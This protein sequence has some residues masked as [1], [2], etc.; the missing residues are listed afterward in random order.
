VVGGA[1]DAAVLDQIS[2]GV[3]L[4][5]LV[6]RRPVLFYCHFPDK[7]LSLGRQSPSSALYRAPIDWLEER[8]TAAADVIFANSEFTR[9]TTAAEFRFHRSRVASS[10]RASISTR[11]DVP[12]N[13]A[14]VRLAVRRAVDDA[15]RRAAPLL[16][17]INRFERKKRSTSRSPPLAT[18]ARGG[19]RAAA[20]GPRRTCCCAA[21]TTTP[22]PRTSSTTPSSSSAPPSS[23]CASTSRLCARSPTTSAPFCSRARAAP[24][25]AAQRALWHRAA[26]GHVQPRAGGRVR[27]GGPRETVRRRRHRPPL[28]RVRRRRV[29]PR[30]RRHF[31]RPASRRVAMGDAGRARVVANFTLAA[32]TKSLVAHI[33]AT[34]CT[35]NEHILANFSI[36]KSGGTP[37]ARY[38]GGG[39]V[40]GRGG[41]TP[42]P[43]R[44][45]RQIV[46]RRRVARHARQ[47]DVGN[48][49]IDVGRVVGRRRDRPVGQLAIVA[50]HRRRHLGHDGRGA[51]RIAVGV[52]LRRLRLRE[53]RPARPA[54]AA[55]RRWW[56]RAPWRGSSGAP[57]A[58]GLT[59]A[60][61]EP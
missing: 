39:S 56:R 37:H 54:T 61:A 44:R 29:W 47:R 22:W 45:R 20:H 23:A 55:A 12:A 38:G 17:S 35:C 3:P 32:F 51:N 41:A 26:R 18:M 10:I 8:T 21:A 49:G 46:H 42:A 31:A 14:N 25:H 59:P 53:S 58:D 5:R 33:E 24:L 50:L 15:R 13:L 6:R 9:T 7:L 1:F 52:K 16:L 4:L 34:R 36:Y 40:D 11:Y 27:S 43:I 30:R 60:K 57:P 48:F 2:L 19:G 28:R